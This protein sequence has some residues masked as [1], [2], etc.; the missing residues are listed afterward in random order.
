MDCMCSSDHLAATAGFLQTL[1]VEEPETESPRPANG[2]TAQL[3]S[4]PPVNEQ[5][6]SQPAAVV[7]DLAEA[8]V[9]QP[10]ANNA[11]QPSE[12]QAERPETFAV[13]ATDSLAPSPGVAS[14]Q[15][16]RERS[17]ASSSQQKAAGISSREGSVPDHGV[18]EGM[19]EREG[20]SRSQSPE[21]VQPPA[22]VKPAAQLPLEAAERLR[23]QWQSLRSKGESLDLVERFTVV[24]IAYRR[25]VF[26]RLFTHLFPAE[27]S[28]SMKC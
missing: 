3:G 6:A 10:A 11:E 27:R 12:L 8:D 18:S 9:S 24:S 21:P 22:A 23:E 26:S 7:D 19:R 15:G 4:A 17:P 25:S 20:E 14:H 5:T 28:R 2:I 16:L 13:G 1:G